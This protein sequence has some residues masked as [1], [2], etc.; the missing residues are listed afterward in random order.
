VTEEVKVRAAA[1]LVGLATI[2]LRLSA[3]A[4]VTVWPRHSV[5]G[6]REKYIIR[7]PNE[8][9]VATLR[10]EAKFPAEARV[11]SLEQT[12]GW[13]VEAERDASGAI[14]EA[15]WSGQLP[16]DQFT[17]FGVLA[18][19]PKV[20]ETLTWKFVQIY[21]DGTRVD[22]TGAP[23]SATPAPQVQLRGDGIATAPP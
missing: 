10:L 20:G 6:A 3:V 19:N 9:R 17:E 5:L 8:R 14:V 11:S 15:R 22:W 21:A 1:L 16:P 2:A 23:G 12:P 4:H 13:T 18:L 7:M